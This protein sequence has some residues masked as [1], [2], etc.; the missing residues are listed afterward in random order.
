MTA[1]TL[2]MSALTLMKAPAV[3]PPLLKVP[4]VEGVLPVGQL[5]GVRL[6]STLVRPTK[7]PELVLA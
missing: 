6:F 5:D 3:P 1:L 7:P 2:V 4:S